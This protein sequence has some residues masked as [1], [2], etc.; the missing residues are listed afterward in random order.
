MSDKLIKRAVFD[1]A[2]S[3]WT[4][5][6]DKTFKVGQVLNFEDV[7]PVRSALNDLRVS[8]ED[9]LLERSLLQEKLANT[10]MN[11]RVKHEKP[12][13]NY[14]DL[15]SQLAYQSLKLAAF[16]DNTGFY[17]SMAELEIFA[18]IGYFIALSMKFTLEGDG[19]AVTV[20][21]PREGE[22]QHENIVSMGAS[23]SEYVSEG[24][25]FATMITNLRPLLKNICTSELLCRTQEVDVDR[26]VPAIHLPINSWPKLLGMLGWVLASIDMDRLPEVMP[27][28]FNN[29][30]AKDADAVYILCLGTCGE[31]ERMF[32][33]VIP[34]DAVDPNGSVELN[35]NKLAYSLSA[36][37]SDIYMNQ[38]ALKSYAVF[39]TTEFS[40]S[41]VPV[42]AIVGKDSVTTYS[43]NQINAMQ[44]QDSAVSKSAFDFAIYQRLTD[45]ISNA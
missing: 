14:D 13:E 38:F 9:L 42:A 6:T 43:Q 2:T 15:N 28:I 25:K 17:K 11:F 23:V 40:G 27:E 44:E 12:P 8:Y 10:F 4:T 41:R 19:L 5:D 20:A 16:T 18:E 29:I 30:C 21:S 22:L 1:E 35:I 24:A 45:C 37:T 31:D 32:L 34:A 26:G 33:H 39:K 7:G 36:M 3:T